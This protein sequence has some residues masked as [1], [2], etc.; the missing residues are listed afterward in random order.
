MEAANEL[1]Q[2]V[3]GNKNG[4]MKERNEVETHEIARK[5]RSGKRRRENLEKLI[6]KYGKLQ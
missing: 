2:N 3:D 1:R 6:E 5:E 4:P